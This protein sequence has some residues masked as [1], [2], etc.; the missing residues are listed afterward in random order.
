M[1]S[2]AR[3]AGLAAASLALTLFSAAPAVSVAPPLSDPHVLAHLDLAAGQMPENIVLEPD[4]SAD[5][6]F[7]SARQIARIGLDG[8]TEILGTL[9]APAVPATPVV[10][11]AAVAGIARAD[12]GTLYVNYATGTDDLTGV[13]RLTPGGVP[14]RIAALPANGL[15]NGLTLDQQHGDLYVADA[16]LGTVWRVSLQDGTRTAWATGTEL[17]PTGF[18]GANGIRSHHGAIWVSNTDRGTVLR[19]PICPD[20]SA[21]PIETRVTGIEGIDDFGFTGHGDTLLAARNA[22]NE[23]VYVTPG[24]GAP[25]VVLTQQ[26]GLSNPTSVALCGGAVYVTS[27]AFLTLQDPNVLLARIDA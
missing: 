10:G 16:V 9:P 26:D 22:A 23:V 17:Q 27:A 21:G 6:T 18:L 19:I 8:H 15:P 5:V 1:T 24:G 25:T 2:F 20:G 13:W 11:F 12:D 3:P 14:E 4:G 7:I